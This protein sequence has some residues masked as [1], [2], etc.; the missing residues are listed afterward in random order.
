[1]KS[2][3]VVRRANNSSVLA[4]RALLPLLA[5]STLLVGSVSAASSANE[6]PLQAGAENSSRLGSFADAGFT[7]FESFGVS[8]RFQTLAVD[9]RDGLLF[10]TFHNQTVEVSKE[11]RF[12]GP[13]TT[14]PVAAIDLASGELI[15]LSGTARYTPSGTDGT[16]ETTIN[17]A[18]IENGKLHTI[19]LSGVGT[20][21]L[22]GLGIRL[23]VNLNAKASTSPP[24]LQCEAEG[25]PFLSHGEIFHLP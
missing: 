12:A 24:H 6:G 20:G 21:N 18:K 1:M 8:C 3:V 23:Q 2:F 11:K 25:G 4:A 15:G 14:T 13:A 16:W 22:Q 5:A 7:P 17:G 9:V 10:V 19:F